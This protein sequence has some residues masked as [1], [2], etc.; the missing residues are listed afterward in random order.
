MKKRNLLSGLLILVL[1]ATLTPLALATGTD[2]DSQPTA[3]PVFI[4]GQLAD[5]GTDA[6]ILDDTTY[7]S[8]RSFSM[9]MGADSVAWYKGT[10]TVYATDLTLTA[11][12]SNIY[13]IANDRYLFVPDGCI[14]QND[15][16]MVPVRVL[17]EAF[18]ATV[19]WSA[20]EQAVYVTKGTG[21]IESGSTFYD[22]TDLYWMS[23]IISAEARG[24]SFIGKIAVGGVIMNRVASPEFPNTVYDVIFD[25]R[26]GVQFTPAYSGAI[27][28]TPS[29][30]CVIAAKIALDGGNTAG[31]SLYFSQSSLS[32][33]AARYRPYTMTIGNHS[34]YA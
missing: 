13:L 34:F 15:S 6:F 9:A 29:E 28:N 24:E 19:A 26:Y 1:L 33:W 12:S 2:T 30:E 32:C 8:L 16:M 21:P 7:V 4:D 18:G 3:V 23:R 27:Y 10:A 20:E 31:D 5:L 25:R 14:L 22:E 11:S 17:A